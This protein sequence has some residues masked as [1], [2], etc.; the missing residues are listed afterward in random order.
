MAG[1]QRNGRS[2][3]DPGRV[4]QQLH[5]ILGRLAGTAGSH[6]LLARALSLARDESPGLRKA[7]L[8]SD[9]QMTGLGEGLVPDD[10]QRRQESVMV[11][12]AHVI[13]LLHTF[14]GERLTLQL[15]KEGW[16]DLILESDD[17]LKEPR[18]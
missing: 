14:I 7:H 15:I 11:L 18:S 2:E 16:P 3:P 9:G 5:V 4:I 13:E 17:D 12:V 10:P 1:S 6:S 8:T